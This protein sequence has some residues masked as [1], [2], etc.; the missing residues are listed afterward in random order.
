[1]N[2]KRRLFLLITVA[3]VQLSV[4]SFMVWQWETTL[5]NGQSFSWITEPIDPYDAFR[6]RYIDLGFKETTGPAAAG[7]TFRPGQTVYAHLG[8][9]A[10]G[11]T[12]IEQVSRQR[13]PNEAYV[14]A[15]IRYH[16]HT[17]NKVYLDLPFRRYYLPENLA[18]M[19]ED[20]YRKHAK[21][22]GVAVIRLKNGYGVIETIYLNN[23]P[24]QEYLQ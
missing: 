12:F 10:A 1:M 2:T 8:Q 7:E 13:P 16:N 23:R 22:Q 15:K 18:P 20:L 3:I 21:G 14:N 6:G 17:T 19:A 9:D 4:L 5:T 11:M 24:L